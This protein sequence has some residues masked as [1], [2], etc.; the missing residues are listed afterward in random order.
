MELSLVREDRDGRTA[1]RPVV[2]RPAGLGSYVRKEEP[3][4][5]SKWEI[6]HKIST[7]AGLSQVRSLVDDE[8]EAMEGGGVATRGA[9]PG[10]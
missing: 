3:L 4:K 2:G 8:L 6:H 10:A 5:A 9:D 7:L 1:G